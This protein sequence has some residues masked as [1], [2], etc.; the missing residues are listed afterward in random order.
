MEKEAK[1]AMRQVGESVMLPIIDNTISTVDAELERKEQACQESEP[2]T[3]KRYL[4][5]TESLI[6]K[7]HANSKRRKLGEQILKGEASTRV[8][9][10]KVERSSTRPAKKR[11]SAMPMRQLRAFSGWQ[12]LQLGESRWPLDYQT[13]VR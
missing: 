13:P 7:Q 12:P 4:E 3:R 2:L 9:G 5:E 10:V 11:S 1:Q 6:K 8:Q